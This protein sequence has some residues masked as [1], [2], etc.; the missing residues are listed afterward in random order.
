MFV[1]LLVMYI[2]FIKVLIFFFLQYGIIRL[3]YVSDFDLVYLI[4]NMKMDLLFY[5]K[6]ELNVF[7]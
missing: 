2:F 3:M 4:E 1:K 7:Y 5:D 6:V